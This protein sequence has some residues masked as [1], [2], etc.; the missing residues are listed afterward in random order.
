M[1][2]VLKTAESPKTLNRFLIKVG[3]AKIGFIIVQQR[4]KCVIRNLVI[5]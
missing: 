3:N 2:R 4:L 1:R 5:L